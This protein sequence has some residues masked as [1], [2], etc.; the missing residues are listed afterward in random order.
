MII[1]VEDNLSMVH[2][3]RVS[4][5]EF[6]GRGKISV[7]FTFQGKPGT[8]SP[9]NVQVTGYDKT[10][11]QLF[12]D[13]QETGDGRGATAE[14]AEIKGG[15]I[16]YYR[17]VGFSQPEF[18]LPLKTMQQMAKLDIKFTRITSEQISHKDAQQTDVKPQ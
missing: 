1:V 12:Q 5:K 13:S 4:V 11:T 17:L 6:G 3:I 16:T 14:E 18:Y 10:G 2:W 7:R 8:Y 15:F 9:M